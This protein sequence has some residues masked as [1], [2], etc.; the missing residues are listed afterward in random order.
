MGQGWY[1]RGDECN[2]LYAGSEPFLTV[3]SHGAPV[4]REPTLGSW[5][6]MAPGELP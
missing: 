4:L 2:L 5:A 6:D 1:V 3:H